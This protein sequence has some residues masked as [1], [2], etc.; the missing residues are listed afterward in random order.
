MITIPHQHPLFPSEGQSAPMPLKLPLPKKASPL[1]HNALASGNPRKK[2]QQTLKINER[3]KAILTAL[4]HGRYYTASQLHAQFWH[5]TDGSLPAWM[6]AAQ[7]KVYL[8]REARLIREIKQR[9]LMG[10]GD[11]PY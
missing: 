3:V 6:R 11:L 2:R 9:V 4:Y 8:M 1:E 10:Q 7:Q 5:N